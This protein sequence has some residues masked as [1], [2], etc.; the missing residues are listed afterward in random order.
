MLFLHHRVQARASSISG[1][2]ILLHRMRTGAQT[3]AATRARY[4]HTPDP[5]ATV[6][7]RSHC[8]ARDRRAPFSALARQEWQVIQLGYI[9]DIDSERAAE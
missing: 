7:R 9:V 4:S 6:C 5:L 8:F 3:I 2:I 1:S